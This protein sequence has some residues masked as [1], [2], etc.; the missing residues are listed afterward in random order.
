MRAIA[1][2]T[3]LLVALPAGAQTAA[4][5]LWIE[6]T[7]NVRK[8]LPG[9]HQ[10][11]DVSETEQKPE[12]SQSSKWQIVLDMFHEQ[13]RERSVRV[14]GSIVDI[15]DGRDAFRMAEGS[16]IERQKQGGKHFPPTPSPYNFFNV[17]VWDAVELERRPCG[18]PGIDH[19]CVVLQA[20]YHFVNGP[21]E[22]PEVESWVPKGTERI[23]VDTVTG[24]IVRRSSHEWNDAP[25]YKFQHDYD[26]VLTRVSYGAPADASIFKLTPGARV[27]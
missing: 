1:F 17:A 10:E 27:K 15:F 2:L 5:T 18:V 23:V 12:C 8:A 21:R 14:S 3:T 25:K 26:Y 9:L 22:D 13:F 6:L 7:Q 19:S 20:S 24:A 4:G 16:R 11:F